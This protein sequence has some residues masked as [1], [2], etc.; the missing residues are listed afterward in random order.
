MTRPTADVAERNLLACILL[1]P[2]IIGLIAETVQPDDFQGYNYRAVYE[3]MLELDADGQA[4]DF[5]TILSRLEGK[6][7][8]A[9]VAELPDMLP[10][11]RN[12][13][14]LAKLVRDAATLRRLQASAV[15]WVN[16][17]K[18][19]ETDAAE[20]LARAHWDL[21]RLSD[22]H[23]RTTWR[24]AHAVGDENR[25]GLQAALD[26]TGHMLN[27]VPTGFRSID[28]Y[29]DGFRP[30][31]LCYLAGRPS[32]GKTALALAMAANM[33]RHGSRVA[34]LS[35][36]MSAEQVAMRLMSSISS[37]PLYLLRGC[38]VKGQMEAIDQAV[39]AMRRLPLFIDDGARLTPM[40]TRL[41]V[42]RLQHEHG[43]DVVFIDYVGLMAWH[44][45]LDS[46][47]AELTEI[48]H[49]LKAMAKDMKL[50]II[51]LSQLRRQPPGSKP[52][53]PDLSDLRDSG[54]LE[55]DAD[56]CLFIHRTEQYLLDKTP[57]DEVGKAEVLIAKQ[58]NGPTGVARMAFMRDFCQFA[59]LAPT[60][61]SATYLP[62]GRDYAAG[63]D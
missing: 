10:D 30:G 18:D 60:M 63:K 51:A 43:V 5:A 44:E 17:A 13:I 62:T 56:I 50:P 12:S 34:F 33:A 28:K 1:Q 2:E 49:A 38:Q 9:K 39:E 21:F 45:R 31:D 54:A 48:S 15:E 24:T 32:Q 29:L 52:A 37:I 20:L 23:L 4:V 6:V 36:E 25:A 19:P 55:Q 3:A 14:G 26:G 8:A 53:R 35:L 27:V 22:S 40:E 59:D 58:R 11:I 41:K 47:Y 61:V 46:K 7:D 16:A 42:R 57:E